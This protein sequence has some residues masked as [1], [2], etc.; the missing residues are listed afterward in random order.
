MPR[1]LSLCLLLPA[2]AGITVSCQQLA[3]KPPQVILWQEGSPADSG[4]EM[5]GPGSFRLDDGMITATGG[6]GMLWFTKQDFQDFE[7][8]LEWMVE[9]V[10]HNSGVF[11]RFPHPGDDPWVA[12]N[13]GY[14]IQICDT[15]GPKHDTGSVYSF[16]QATGIPTREAGSW[17]HYRIRVVG[18]EYRIEVNG[19]LVNEFTGDRTERGY[20]GLQNHDDASPV[21][22]RDIR[23]TEL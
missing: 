2:L 5:C 13:Q 6:M 14:E 4:W 22:F 21:H 12:V 9:D 18:Q 16:Q 1:T 7:L 10:A 8:E 20:I 11:V 19:Q 3:P 23:V 17:N 15:A